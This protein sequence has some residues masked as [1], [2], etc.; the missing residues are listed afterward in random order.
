MTAWLLA[1]LLLGSV[2]PASASP[3]PRFRGPNGTGIASDKDIPV[4]WTEA[5]GLLW[6]VAIP[7][8]GNSSPV[9]W[10]DHVFVQSAS[11]DGRERL[12]LCLRATDGKAL[13]SRSVAGS[14]AHTH[15]RNT[16]ASA[17][18]ATD[19]ERVYAV[20]WDGQDLVMRAFDFQGRLVWDRGLGGFTSQHGAGASPIVFDGQIF[21]LNDFDG[22]ATV[23]A[24][25]ARTGKVLW[26][27]RRRAYRACYST[28]FVLERPGEPAQLIVA[29][30]GG[31]TS[32]HPRTGAE[33]WHWNWTFS[34][35]PLRTVSS[36]VAGQDMIFATSGDGTGPRH[37]VAL[38]L[39][40]KGNATRVSLA[41][42]NKKVFPYLPSLLT[43]GSCLYFVNDIGLAGCCVAATGESVWTGRLGGN[44]LASPVLIDGK[45][46]AVSEEGDISV[47]PAAR[48]FKLLGKSSVGEPVIATPAVADNR[49]FIR[50][51]D[52]LFCIGKPA[53]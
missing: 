5:D 49:L 38:K 26:Q 2:C 27:M 36:P 50:G 14:P 32:Y 46:Y 33:N 47:F 31:I 29:S 44:V 37:T 6:K 13:W 9:V 30:T 8:A 16:L 15:D 42:E 28:R 25:D 43:S 18:P 4:Q 19:G 11:A 21:Y 10:G 17:T 53:K 24:L 39:D 41:W 23:L 48:A 52:H 12:L 1:G 51:K 20:F 45:V 7:G 35:M 34:G 3:W 40:G 22:K